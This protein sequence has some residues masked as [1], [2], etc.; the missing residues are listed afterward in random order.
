MKDLY[1]IIKQLQETSSTN[2]KLAIMQENKANEL[3]KEYMR[4]ATCPS[5]NFYI[6]ENTI[7]KASKIGSHTF[8]S[9]HANGFSLGTA[10]LSKR[11]ITGQAAKNFIVMTMNDL[12]E[13]HQK[14]YNML[15]LKDIKAKIGVTLVNKVWPNLCVDISYQ[16]C[17]LPDEKNLRIF[18]EVT[19]H[20]VVQLK[21]DGMYAALVM[22]NTLTKKYNL[23]TRN[24]SCFPQETARKLLETSRHKEMPIVQNMVFE[25][26][27]LCYK[28]GQLMPRRQGN[29][30]LNSLMQGGECPDDV[31]VKYLVW[32]CLML[33]D[34]KQ[35]STLLPYS[36]C[37]NNLLMELDWWSD[38]KI[39]CIPH[40][41][42]S[43]L[44]EAYAVNR[45][46]LAQGYEG[47]IIKTLTHK[48]R[49]GTSKE[50]VKLKLAVEID[51]VWKDSV[52]GKGKAAG[53]LGA[54]CL[55]SECGKLKV[56][57]GTGFSDTQRREL[58]ENKDKLHGSVVTISANDIV[59]REGSIDTMSL[60]LPVFLEL[61]EKTQ[62]DSLERIQQ[63]F[64][65]AKHIS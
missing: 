29:G 42:V 15:L 41:F 27:I 20:F 17:S 18:K 6:T 59:S 39:A 46:W 35:G 55:E 47:S 16:R 3:F 60:F 8:D 32:N 12:D 44:Q 13:Q 21:A 53:M 37:F 14:L 2:E 63:I 38:G 28:N 30:I 50:C 26:E 7:P 25:G 43:S 23:Y 48:W 40:A 65:A 62:A 24:G 58:W 57:V 34:W 56:D 5:I 31:E 49:D 45:R 4:L 64:N 54:M 9:L 1:D 33:E 22:E 51:L 19:R 52:E 11:S 10:E 61:R 36:Q